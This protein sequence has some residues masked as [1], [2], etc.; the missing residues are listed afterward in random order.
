MR[1][2]CFAE[3]LRCCRFGNYLRCVP[4]RRIVVNC[5]ISRILWHCVV[6]HRLAFS[7][8]IA[9][10]KTLQLLTSFSCRVEQISCTDWCEY[11]VNHPE[12]AKNGCTS[13]V[14]SAIANPRASI[15]NTIVGAFCK[16]MCIINSNSYVCPGSTERTSLLRAVW[17][18]VTVE[19]R[20]YIA[21][22]GTMSMSRTLIRTSKINLLAVNN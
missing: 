8:L 9:A 7:S 16:I 6:L 2:N 3:S 17:P 20:A 4:I 21:G 10:N 15:T 18:C 22:L 12:S 11:I 19:T 1:P 13:E 14:S 5:S